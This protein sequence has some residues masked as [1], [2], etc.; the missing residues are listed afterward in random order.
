MRFYRVAEIRRVWLGLKTKSATDCTATD[1]T[2]IIVLCIRHSTVS[3]IL[4]Y[5]PGLRINLFNQMKVIECEKFEP[6]PEKQ[7]DSSK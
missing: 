6:R 3:L 5:T 7:R 1:T 2:T 4:G